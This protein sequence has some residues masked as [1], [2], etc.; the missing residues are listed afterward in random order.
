MNFQLAPALR[1]MYS[2][3]PTH[4]TLL[5][6]HPIT[7]SSLPP[8]FFSFSPNKQIKLEGRRR[9]VAAREE[10][11]EGMWI[12]F[13]SFSFMFAMYVCIYVCVCAQYVRW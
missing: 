10:G 13:L 7:P 3:Q 2:L 12:F 11:K 1:S 4:N 8:P 6:E 9:E 5:H